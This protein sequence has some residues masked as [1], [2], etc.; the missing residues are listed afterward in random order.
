MMSFE[1]NVEHWNASA[2]SAMMHDDFEKASYML[3]SALLA[4]RGIQAER[5]EEPPALELEGIL[6]VTTVHIEGMKIESVPLPNAAPVEAGNSIFSVFNH[7]LLPKFGG[8]SEDGQFQRTVS[9]VLFNSGLCHHLKGIKCGVSSDLQKALGFYQLAVDV[10]FDNTAAP[11]SERNELLA[12]ALVNNIGHLHES[13]MRFQKAAAC[14]E[15][16]NSFF[17]SL[18]TAGDN[19]GSARNEI[20]CFY[21]TAF[22]FGEWVTHPAAAA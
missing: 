22:L 14:L 10:V 11:V 13:F 8:S 6:S 5:G 21:V 9:V 2:I 20:F 16:I 17:R 3:K 4:L 19:S 1:T 12:L 18:D 7:A 15:W